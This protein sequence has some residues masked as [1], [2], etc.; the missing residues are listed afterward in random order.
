MSTWTHPLSKADF[1]NSHGVPHWL[2]DNSWFPPE[3]ALHVT[4]CGSV[5]RNII[6]KIAK[7]INRHVRK[8]IDSGKHVVLLV[9]GHSSRDGVEWLE[10][11][12]KLN[13]VVVRLPA[14]TTHI[15]QPC[16]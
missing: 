11:C 9:D 7:H 1:T 8:T 5:D 15:L 2:C 16:D 12:E 4:K 13:I 14:N 10:V 6:V 3:T